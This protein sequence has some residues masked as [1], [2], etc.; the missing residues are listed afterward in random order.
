MSPQSL[1][2]VPVELLQ[3]GSDQAEAAPHA[4]RGERYAVVASVLFVLAG[5]LLLGWIAA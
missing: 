5:G 2:F 3:R 4:E 1:L